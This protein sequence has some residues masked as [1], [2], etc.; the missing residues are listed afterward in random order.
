MN[1]TKTRLLLGGMAIGAVAAASLS[2]SPA[3]HADGKLANEYKIC[4]MLEANPS[5]ATIDLIASTLIP[6][7]GIKAA[8]DDVVDATTYICPQ[9]YGLV[10]SYINSHAG[11]TSN[12][13]KTA[14]KSPD[15][16]IQHHTV[17]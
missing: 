2:C 16:S 13:P 17:V 9:Y 5:F 14:P 1:K 3:A 4:Q 6:V 12:P 10:S 7:V 11:Y 15:T 8:A